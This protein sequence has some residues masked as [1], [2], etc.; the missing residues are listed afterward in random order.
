MLT[1]HRRRFGALRRRLRP[2]LSERSRQRI[3]SALQRIN[4]RPLALPPM[5]ES[6]RR[7]LL[8]YYAPWNRRLSGSLGA[9]FAP[10]TAMA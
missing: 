8:D 6:V 5:S 9:D 1:A 10:W 4:E 3:R 2:L 7:Q